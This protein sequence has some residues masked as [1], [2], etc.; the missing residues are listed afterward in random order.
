[1]TLDADPAT[2]TAGGSSILSWSSKNSTSCTASGGWTGTKADAGTFAITPSTSTD[3]ILTCT[4]PNGSDHASVLIAVEAASPTPVAPTVSL[5]ASETTIPA[6]SSSTLKWS[7][8]HASSCV[9]SG[10]WTGTE[11]TSGTRKVSPARTTT[12]TLACTSSAG[13]A[14]TSAKI[15][16]DA[17]APPPTP[18]V[19][20]TASPTSIH[21]GGASTLTWSSTN[22][23]SCTAS[24]AWSGA[25]AVGG[26][27]TVSP[28]STATYTLSCEGSGGTVK[29]SAT[30][31]VNAPK[32]PPPSGTSWVYYDGKFD[33]PGD[34]S[35]VAKPDYTDTSGNPLSGAYDVKLTLEGSYG[36]WLP[37]AQNWDFNSAGYTKLT[38]ALK[39]TVANQRWNVY[40]VKVGDVPVGIYLNVLNY[41]PA[42]V[43]G[44]WNTYTV[45]LSDLG[46][47][48]TSIYK[49]CIQDQTGLSN[50]VWYVDNVGFAP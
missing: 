25:E 6:G 45:P 47:L 40:F 30:I 21:S 23:D 28:S 46:V 17:D 36:G 26:S 33:W 19:T 24:D 1:V 16:V 13:T 37:Y 4:G 32:G 20:L 11:T 39:P 43:V 29:A 12:F 14:Q 49:F 9:G 8:E 10:G 27:Q 5:T 18:T 7:S 22:A 38:F 44:Q 48:G 15:T 50:N 3:Y 31:A 34:Y 35:F 41:G 2:V 42:P